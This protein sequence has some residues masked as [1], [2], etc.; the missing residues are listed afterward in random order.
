MAEQGQQLQRV[1]ILYWQVNRS[2]FAYTQNVMNLG[3]IFALFSPHL[4]A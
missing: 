3:L 4:N 1:R 2:R